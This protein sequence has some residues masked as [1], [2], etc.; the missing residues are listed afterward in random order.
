VPAFTRVGATRYGALFATLAKAGLRPGE[1]LALQPRDIDFKAGTLAVERAVNLGRL[2][3]TKTHEQRTVD[4]SP[5]LARTL[6]RHLR[7]LK[8]EALRRGW[9][10]PAW[11]LPN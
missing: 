2:K 7:W 10:E 8:E 3:S 11:L 4:L 1:A 9:G 5:D 6:Q